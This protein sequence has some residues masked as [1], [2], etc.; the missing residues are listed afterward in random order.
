[1]IKTT[2]NNIPTLLL[3]KREFDSLFGRGAI[4]TCQDGLW[5]AQKPNSYSDYLKTGKLWHTIAAF[6]TQTQCRT[7][8]RDYL[9]A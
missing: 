7:F 2:I 4:A 3:G 6:D 5:L 8:V 9:Y 1:M